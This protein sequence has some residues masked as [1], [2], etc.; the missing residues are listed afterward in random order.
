[1]LS[2]I[3]V[4]F[5]ALALLC[6]TVTGR[7]DAVTAAVGTGASEAVTLAISIAGLMCFWSGVMEVL[8]RAGALE[9]LSKLLSPLLRRLFPSSSRDSDIL[10]SLAS[11]VSANLLGLGNA[12]TPMGIRAATGMTRLSPRGEASD[13]LC[14]LVVINTASIQ[15]LPT[16]AAALRASYG[17]AA[18]FDILPAVWLSSAVSVCAGLAAAEILRRLWS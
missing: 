2:V 12:A 16:T 8:R 14:R 7:L 4:A 9:A 6:G 18:P 1:M 13:E 15:L 5:L 3:W 11:N 10:S 17:S